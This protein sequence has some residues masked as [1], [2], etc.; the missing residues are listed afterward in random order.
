MSDW[1]FRFVRWR[2]RRL[3]KRVDWWNALIDPLARAARRRGR[4]S[5][6]PQLKF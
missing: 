2:V 5:T 6:P 3:M 4:A 1:F